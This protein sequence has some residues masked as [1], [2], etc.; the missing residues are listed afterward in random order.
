MPK[1]EHE[2]QKSR[3]C[4][5]A[6]LYDYERMIWGAHEVRMS[7]VY[8]GAMNLRHVLADLERVSGTILEIGCGAGSMVRA[9]GA[10]R[11][12]LEVSGC[13]LS[14]NTI[15]EAKRRSV[16]ARLYGADA[17]S[18]PFRSGAF[19]GAFLFDVLEHLPDPSCAISEAAR[20]LEPNGLLY[21]SVPMEGRL[22]TVQGLLRRLGWRAFENTVGHIQAFEINSLK[23][24]LASAG[25]RT[26]G[27]RWGGHLTSQIAHTGYVL[28][29]SI[30]RGPHSW[31]S[32]E[33]RLSQPNR[34]LANRIVGILKGVVA[35]LSYLESG[36]LTGIP[37]AAAHITALNQRDW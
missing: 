26:T 17:T 23:Q 34:S 21:I 33:S 27:V 31:M 32:V 29:L 24:M 8:L 20:V 37:G 28:W 4:S 30:T 22:W 2:R 6:A 25:L 15:R 9:I 36:L 11:P 7:P 13:D 3:D 19:K 16:T 1:L 14:I 5:N 35:I 18:L 12:D 10:Y